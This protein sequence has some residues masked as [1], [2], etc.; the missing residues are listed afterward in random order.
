MRFESPVWLALLAIIPLLALVFAAGERRGAHNLRRFAA[1]RL[2]PFLGRS[3]GWPR[4]LRL[5]LMMAAFA[6]LAIALARPSYGYRLREIHSKGA[7]ILF[8]VDVSRSM[9]CTDIAPNR[10]TRAKMAAKDMLAVARGH[11]IG[12]I[13]FSRE[14]F[15]QCPLTLDETAVTQSLD[16]LGTTN[17]PKQGT[18]LADP[19]AEARKA[20]ASSGENKRILVLFTDGEDLEGNGLGEARETKDMI[21]VTVGTGTVQGAP[22]PVSENDGS[23]YIKDASGSFVTSRLDSAALDSVAAATNG[24][25]QHVSAPSLPAQFKELINR[26]EQESKAD[27]TNIRIPIIRYRWPLA[28]ALVLL[29]AEAFI[30]AFRRKGG[31]V[32][33]ALLLFLPA[34]PDNASAATPEAAPS[35]Q[36]A[37]ALENGAKAATPPVNPREE[38]NKGVDFFNAGNYPAATEAFGK[39]ADHCAAAP[40]ELKKQI[41]GNAGA[42]KIAQAMSLIPQG[43]TPLSQQADSAARELLKGAKTDIE[44]A[45]SLAPEDALLRKNFQLIDEILAELD[46][47]KQKAEEQK[48]KKEPPKP[49]E[50]KKK[51]D[52]LPTPEHKEE[53]PPPNKDDKNNDDDKGDKKQ[54]G[55]GGQDKSDKDQSDQSQGGSDGQQGQSGQSGENS[56]QGSSG[57]NQQNQSQQPSGGQDQEKPSQ[58]QSGQDQKK[59]NSGKDQNQ[60]PQDQQKPQ[61]GDKNRDQEKQPSQGEQP[62]PQ[63]QNGAD[64]QQGSSGQNQPQGGQKP[65]SQAGDGQNPQQQPRDESGDNRQDQKKQQQDKSEKD[66][67][68]PKE[69]TQQQGQQPQ[70]QPQPQSNG[71]PQDGGKDR[72]PKEQPAQDKQQQAQNGGDQKQGE[73]SQAGNEGGQDES[74]KNGLDRSQQQGDGQQQAPQ[75]QAGDKDS[76]EKDAQSPTSGKDGKQPQPQ[77]EAGRDEGANGNRQNSPQP[78]A[79]TSSGEDKAQAPKPQ[80]GGKEQGKEAQAEAAASPKPGTQDNSLASGAQEATTGKAQAAAGSPEPQREGDHTAALTRPGEDSGNEGDKKAAAGIAKADSAPEGQEGTPVIA[81]GAMTP[82]EAEQLLKILQ[83]DEKLL[84][85]GQ[86]RNQRKD[87]T[88][89]RDW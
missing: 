54:Q 5:C 48:Q 31:T 75:P 76:G 78:S 26:D 74:K 79:G 58:G 55:G 66:Q 30:P 32:L 88:S 44:K 33:L 18:S 40:D 45:L 14:A 23:G 85:A 8:A 51:D 81:P 24:F 89:G 63:S 46:R 6:L 13:P 67:S 29:I 49:D 87:N 42:T 59:P 70:Q 83:D 17:I 11:R 2:L 16:A 77:P 80:Q 86:L 73:Q 9:L 39:A 47:R 84:P 35:V 1:P 57:Q 41:H 69:N 27:A 19:I 64:N 20:F 50:E 12:I 72:T 25:Y 53:P 38:Y 22:V 65:Q 10:L 34:S 37:A 15:L 71:N 36:P 56:Q 28:A 52:P 43:D 68:S 62:Q 4:V 82:A 7:D 60:Q 61:D 3:A 21:I